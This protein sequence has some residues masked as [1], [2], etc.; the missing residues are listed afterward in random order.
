MTCIQFM[1]PGLL[2]F[3]FKI[4]LYSRACKFVYEPTCV[5]QQHP[6]PQFQHLIGGR[7]S[8]EQNVAIV[9]EISVFAS[10][11]IGCSFSSQPFKI[12]GVFNS[13]KTR[14]MSS[15]KDTRPLSTHCKAATA[16]KSFVRCQPERG[17]GCQG[18]RVSLRM[19]DRML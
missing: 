16:V 9:G 1:E 6:V 19:C 10:S 2:A 11:K 15:S 17:I 14:L 5:P 7:S 4:F 13:G 8:I 3:M 18:W 12:T